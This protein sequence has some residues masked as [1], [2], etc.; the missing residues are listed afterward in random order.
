MI[1]LQT[2]LMDIHHKYGTSEMANYKIELL[3][4]QYAK[5][6]HENELKKLNLVEFLEFKKPQRISF[7]NSNDTSSAT[8]CK[9]GCKKNYHK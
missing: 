2:A 8:K 3:T 9:C 7:E 4:K 6:Y 5:E 1:D